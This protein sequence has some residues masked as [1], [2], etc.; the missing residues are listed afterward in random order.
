[1]CLHTFNVACVQIC[2]H[3]SRCKRCTFILGQDAQTHSCAAM[4][5]LV[6]SHHEG[7]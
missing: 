6:L 1:M 4:V 3:I 2:V 5:T 7:L